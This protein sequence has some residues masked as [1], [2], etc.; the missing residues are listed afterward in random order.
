MVRTASIAERIAST[1]LSRVASTRARPPLAFD[2]DAMAVRNAA[3]VGR[4]ESYFWRKSRIARLTAWGCSS[5][6]KWPE[7]F[8]NCS[9]ALGNRSVPPSKYQSG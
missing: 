3:P 6:E 1:N 4:A 5:S 2:G 9:V 7:S 8:T